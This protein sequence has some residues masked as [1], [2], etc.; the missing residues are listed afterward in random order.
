MRIILASLCLLYVICATM[1]N[2]VTSDALVITSPFIVL[3]VLLAITVVGGFLAFIGSEIG[4]PGS[5][6]L[7]GSA[8]PFVLLNLAMVAVGIVYMAQMASRKQ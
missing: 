2:S 7:P 8:V 1:T 6:S 4:S 5:S 3:A